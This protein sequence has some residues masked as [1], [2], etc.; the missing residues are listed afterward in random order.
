MAIYH[1]HVNVISRGKGRSA[2]A[3]AAYRH[4]KKLFD[5]RQQC[6]WDYSNKPNVI[7]SELLIPKNASEL[8]WIQKSC[9]IKCQ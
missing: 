3:A 5:E 7:H 2:V 6:T 4:A 9:F 1:L 8:A